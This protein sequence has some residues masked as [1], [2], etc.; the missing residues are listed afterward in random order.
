MELYTFG[1]CLHGARA[2]LPIPV[3]NCTKRVPQACSWNL[4]CLSKASLD[5]QVRVNRTNRPHPHPLI[6]TTKNAPRTDMQCISQPIIV[7][8]LTDAHVG[9]DEFCTSGPGS[10]TSKLRH[11]HMARVRADQATNTSTSQLG[12]MCYH[13]TLFPLNAS[14]PLLGCVAKV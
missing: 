11:L 10:Q 2:N 6:S 4:L 5:K 1:L 8:G 14:K 9:A 12:S 13:L 3:P 7:P